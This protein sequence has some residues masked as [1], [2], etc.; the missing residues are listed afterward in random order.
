[1]KFAV[2]LLLAGLGLLAYSLSLAPY[3]DESAF[4]ERY[5]RLSSGQSEE[6]GKLRNE[7]LTPKY[8]TQDYGV[9]LL[10][11]AVLVALLNRKRGAP[12]AT[13]SSRKSLGVLALALPVLTVSGFV[14][15]LLQGFRRG[16]FPHWADSMSIPLM[17][18]PVALILLLVWALAHLGMFGGR[19]RGRVPIAHALSRESSWWL[20]F[21]SAATA[22]LILLFAFD[23]I[24]WYVV[25]GLLWLYFYLCLAAER[26]AD[27]A[28]N[29]K[30]NG[31]PSAAVDY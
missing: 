29:S 23:G 22:V 20:L 1:M 21:V 5:M 17:G 28:S 15:D 18:A 31:P 11:A 8:G 2:V 24:Y 27:T 9:T 25:P 19:Y 7:M 30:C 10:L 12:L 3:R 14:F 26:R 4:M 6:Y 13:P 16:E